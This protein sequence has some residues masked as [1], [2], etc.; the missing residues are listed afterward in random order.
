MQDLLGYARKNGVILEG[1]GPCQF[2]GSKVSGGVFECLH[3]VDHIAQVLD[4][5][6]PAYY[7]T[8]FLSVDAMAL[9]H[10][11]VHG[12]WNNHIHLTRLFLIFE[13]NVQWDYA[14]TPQLST[15]INHYKK[16]KTAFLTPPPLKHRGQLTTSDLL[17]ATSPEEGMDIVKKWAIEVYHS[18][19]SHHSLVSS[20]AN[21]FIAKY[22]S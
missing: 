6:N 13:R 8:R 7:L 14:K 17:T 9:Q 2:C 11:E 10:C 1:S 18:F 21:V 5:T 22:H 15:I 20:I 3:N 4:F 12:T 16:N 19:N